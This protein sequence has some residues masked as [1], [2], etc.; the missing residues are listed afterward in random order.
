MSTVSYGAT[1]APSFEGNP[2]FGG[3]GRPV[4]QESDLRD[5]E[6]IGQ[7][8]ADLE[9]SFY[10][11]G[12]DY[13]YPPSLPNIPFD[14]EGHL[15]LFRFSGG[16]VD[17]RSRYVRTERYTAQ[18]KA[19]RALFGTYRNPFSDPPEVA[20]LSRGT[21]NTNIIYHH[22]HLFAL[23]EDSPPVAL[24]PHTLETT[25][26]VYRFGGQMT[27]DT[28]TAHPKLDS[29]TGE[30]VGIAYEAKGLA[31][32]DVACYAFDRE[33]RK[34]WEAWI[35]VPYAGMI[36][37]FAITRSYLA[38][39]VVPMVTD[40]ERMKA[41]HVHFAWDSSLPTWLGVMRRD[42][43]GSDLRWFRGPERCAT[44]VMG[45]FEDGTRVQ[46]DMDMGL[47]NQFPFFPQRDGSPFDP[48]AAQGHVVR[49]SVDLADKAR[50]NYEMETLYPH[51]GVLSRQDDRY[52][53]VPYNTGFMLTFDPLAPFDPRLAAAMP[54]RPQNHWT[55]FDHDR[56]R[57]TSWF[58]GPESGLQE[59]CFAPRRADAPE[60]QGYLLG[61]VN[62]YL[63]NRN[64]LVIL[65]A[66][67]LADGPLATVR[68]P[69]RIPGQV[70][71][72]WVPGSTLAATRL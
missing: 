2:M 4:R 19:G 41:G 72:W 35:Q 60:G 29:E 14:G 16:R 31:S 34:T 67:R 50:P 24:N 37:D 42:G 28:F 47:K 63:E 12:P 68:L 69:T 17:Y 21:A 6:V 57:A 45:A 39:L 5:C 20:G 26:P 8:P 49:L 54:F 66:E 13:Q 65:D 58:V 61:V 30:M 27:A 11:V 15:C 59:C 33:G 51:Q 64:D 10:R 36:H 70:H 46:I 22:G 25:D 23:K 53:S 71:G 1:G 40:V 3:F 52:H 43:D 9:G 32:R 44:H 7:I 62:R 18:A 55:R 38:I 56:R 48:V